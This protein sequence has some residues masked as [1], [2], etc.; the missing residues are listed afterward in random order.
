MMYMSA[1]GPLGR[2]ASDLRLAMGAT[3]GPEGAAA[4]AYCLVPARAAAPPAA[5]TFASA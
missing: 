4:K 2:S 1:L 3:G 5:R